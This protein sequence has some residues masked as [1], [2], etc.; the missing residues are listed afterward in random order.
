M[1]PKLFPTELRPNIAKSPILHVGLVYS[2][3]PKQY[4]D[5]PINHRKQI[6]GSAMKMTILFPRLCLY[7]IEKG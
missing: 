1:K 7:C 3:V 4:I 6:A 5:Q 2:F